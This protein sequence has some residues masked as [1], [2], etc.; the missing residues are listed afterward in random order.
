MRRIVGLLTVTLASGVSAWGNQPHASAVPEPLVGVG[1]E[2]RIGEKV[3]LDLSF[4]AT[5]GRVVM[6][7]E[8]LPADRPVILTLVYYSCPML[9]NMVL[10]GLVEAIRQI[11]WTPGE[12][13]SIVTISIDPRETPDLAARKRE[14]YVA[15]YGRSAPGWYF[16]TD[17][18]GH[19]QQLARQVGFAY[20]YD[21][22]TNQYAHPAAIM[23]LGPGGKISRYLYGVR[24]RTRD[25][26]LALAEASEG[27]V[28]TSY[29]RLLLLC[30]HYDPQAQS[31]VVAAMNIMR[32]AAVL[33]V[34]VLGWVLYRLWSNERRFMS[35]RELG[36]RV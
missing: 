25:L 26:R 7:R 15:S 19:V 17:F 8:L 29:D 14:V 13:F 24:F 2:E 11:P 3:D 6:L 5:D 1:I 36:Q 10:N 33:V 20:R 21:E 12:E 22:K 28:G 35:H 34:V 9:C 18:R 30:Y 16:L 32:G 4:V 27:K 23:V 31:Y